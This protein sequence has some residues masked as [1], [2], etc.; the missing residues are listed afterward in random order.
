MTVMAGEATFGRAERIIARSYTVSLL[1][2]IR[3][4]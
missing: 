3:I 1:E 2:G 4:R